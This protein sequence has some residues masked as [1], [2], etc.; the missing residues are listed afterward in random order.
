MMRGAPIVIM[1]LLCACFVSCHSTTSLS[2]LQEQQE[3]EAL[4]NKDIW[5]EQ[6]PST[7]AKLASKF[8]RGRMKV[9]LDVRFIG[10]KE[11]ESMFCL[12]YVGQQAVFTKQVHITS[13]WLTFPDM[14]FS[15]FHHLPHSDQRLQVAVFDKHP[16]GV[17]G[18]EIARVD[19]GILPLSKKH[20]A[21]KTTTPERSILETGI[22][23]LHSYFGGKS[24][25]VQVRIQSDYT[26][27]S[28]SAGD[29]DAV[30]DATASFKQAMNSWGVDSEAKQAAAVKK[31][32]ADFPEYKNFAVLLVGGYLTDKYP[33]YMGPNKDCLKALG[34]DFSM[35]KIDTGAV[36]DKNADDIA[37]EVEALHAKYSKP[38]ILVGHSKGGIDSSVALAK[39][40]NRLSDKVAGIA[41]LLSPINGALAPQLM[42]EWKL[43]R[44]ITK[45]LNF[46]LGADRKSFEDL[47]PANREK[48]LKA[49]PIDPKIPCFNLVGYSDFEAPS[50]I[51]QGLS[52]LNQITWRESGFMSD[53]MTIPALNIV[54]GCSVALV[55]NVDHAYPAQPAPG[56]PG[57][58]GQ[59]QYATMRSI[60]T[61]I[62]NKKHTTEG[63]SETD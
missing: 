31:F 11:K 47:L 6:N 30:H 34:I 60:L 13:N 17:S 3:E 10:A 46:V 22:R 45:A 58:P 39:H 57:S 49:N 56:E 51:G 32:H 48:F 25:S 16:L 2:L 53:G 27:S 33:G 42:E 37:K 59:Y 7:D 52:A 36:A 28:T 43:K 61:A 21:M 40:K 15:V 41:Y 23:A 50:L 26:E 35:S 9:K 20:T 55:S 29:H 54:P 4:R 14:E 19:F 1:V 63:R 8:L 44:P 38:V 18:V 62:K 24:A 5:M 12:V